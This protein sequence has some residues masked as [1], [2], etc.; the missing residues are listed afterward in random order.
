MEK[1]F[2]PAEKRERL[3]MRILVADDDEAILEITVEALKYLGCELVT[4]NNGKELVEKLQDGGKFDA[5]IT[6]QNMPMMNGIDALEQIRQDARFKDLLLILR[7]A[8]G[9]S[10]LQERVR[11]IGGLYLDKPHSLNA[12]KEALK[13]PI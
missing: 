10:K 11:R 3:S 8:A 13:K 12:L 7:S 2:N 6:D 1:S 4:A 5:I 9:D